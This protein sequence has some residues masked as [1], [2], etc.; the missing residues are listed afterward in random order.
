MSKQ[1]SMNNN[2]VLVLGA[3]GKT[4]SR[5]FQRLS[6]LQWPVRAGSRS[7]I[8]AFNWENPGTWEAALKDIQSV[9]VSYHPD[10]ALPGTVAVIK[11]FTAAAVK[12]GIKNIVLLS[13]RGEP[14]AQACEKIVMASG[15]DW[16]IIRSSWFLQNFSEGN[17]LEPILAGHVALPAGD[18]AEPFIDIDD[19]AEIA[20]AALT[21]N[22]H[23]GK[24]YEVTGLRSLTFKEVI[25]AIATATGQPIQYQR[26]SMEA[27]A[28][29]LQEYGLPAEVIGL[30]TYLFTE[31]LD[32]RNVQTANGVREA[33]GRE[34]SDISAFIKKAIA[35][36]AWQTNTVTA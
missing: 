31:V 29:M 26:I 36:N 5:V 13:G 25:A 30:I 2:T 20:V 9:Y 21:T 15:I 18:I 34:P 6:D 17:F 32:G 22:G 19:I 10:L 8:P 14:E 28:G 12:N 7:A 1:Q 23:T 16:T 24:L 27:Y 3:N 11:E 33:L 35:A 4:G